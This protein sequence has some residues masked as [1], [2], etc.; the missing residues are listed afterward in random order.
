MGAVLHADINCILMVTANTQY[1]MITMMAIGVKYILLR[2][3]KMTKLSSD[4]GVTFITFF[5]VLYISV[6]LAR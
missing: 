2:H 3:G 6:V 5:L 4:Y 1:L